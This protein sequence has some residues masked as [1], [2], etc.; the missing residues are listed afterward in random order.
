MT[1]GR[2]NLTFTAGD[3]FSHILR[4]TDAD[5]PMDLTGYTF[6]AQARRRASDDDA[7]E[8]TVDT[9]GAADG[10]IVLELD[11][12]A[13]LSGAYVWDCEWTANGRTETVLAGSVRVR[14]QV[15]RG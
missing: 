1:P 7:V 3:N 5:G 15:S 8:F 12:T 9:T 6:R 4:F 10:V 13:E 11:D 14:A 2:L